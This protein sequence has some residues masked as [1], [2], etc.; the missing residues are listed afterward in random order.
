ML[1]V[2]SRCYKLPKSLVE[3]VV[4]GFLQQQLLI[5][6]TEQYCADHQLP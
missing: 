6:S 3:A 5:Y 4:V 2:W 1:N